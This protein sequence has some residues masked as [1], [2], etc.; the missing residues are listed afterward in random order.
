MAKN[1]PMAAKMAAD[2]YQAESDF[3]QLS[4][5][6]E[7]RGDKKRHKA[8]IAH[9]KGKLAAMQGVIGDAEDNPAMGGDGGVDE[10]Q[11]MGAPKAK[12]PRTVVGGV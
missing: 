1:A 4:N 2:P 12:A 7:I 11:E 9:G 8:A 5:A 3:R 6:H 10:A